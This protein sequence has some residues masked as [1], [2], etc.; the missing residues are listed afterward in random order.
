[1]L[2]S[3]SWQLLLIAVVLSLHDSSGFVDWHEVLVRIW[4]DQTLELLTKEKNL[5]HTKQKENEKIFAQG[6]VKLWEKTSR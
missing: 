5:C 4:I 2:E 6:S 3:V 1:M